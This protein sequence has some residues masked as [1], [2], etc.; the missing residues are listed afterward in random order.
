MT[1]E[2]SA[3]TETARVSA[4]AERRATSSAISGARA[5]SAEAG[6]RAVH[7]DA[8]Q[9]R[10]VGAPVGRH[11]A[12]LG[13]PGTGKTTVV[14][15][16]VA[17]RIATGAR[18]TDEIMVI[19]ADRRAATR[20]RD[21]LAV[22]VGVPT[23]GPLARALTSFA[24]GIVVAGN[25][26]DG[27]PAP[28][29]LT[30]GEQDAVIADLLLGDD[31][32]GRSDDW[33]AHL[34]AEVRSLPGFRGELRELMA[35]AVEAHVSPSLL[36]ELGDRRLRAEWRAAG[37][38]I[39]QYHE[40]VDAFRDQFYDSTELVHRATEIV[41]GAGPSGT[42][43]GPFAR[44]RSLVVD[45]AEELSAAGA[46]LLAAF[47]RRG[48]DIV[49][50][51][52]PDVACGGFRG[53]NPDVVSRLPQVLDAPADT[54]VLGSSY[55]G[56]RQLADV[57]ERVVARVGTAGAG[58]QRRVRRPNRSVEEP[59]LVTTPSSVAEQVAIVARE[60]RERHVFA[61]V[62]WHDMAVVV[63]SRS[64]IAA[65]ERGL[66]GL[67]VP[68]RVL[69]GGTAL[70]DEPSVRAFV[71]A[72]RVALGVRRLDDSSAEELL[73]SVLGGFDRVELRRLRAA[74][75]QREADAGGVRS[76][77][78]LL[79]E[80]MQL[81]GSLTDLDTRHGRKAQ[82]LADNLRRAEASAADGATVEE[83][84]W[85]LW[86]RARLERALVEQSRGT[87]LAADEANRTLDAIVA[88]FAAA[89]RAVERSPGE[90]PAHFLDQLT[91]SD[92]PEDTLAPRAAGSA[93]V[94]T[95]PVGTVDRDFDTVVICG[96]QEHG[97]PN[98]RQRGTLLASGELADAAAGIDPTPSDARALVLHD[99]LRLLARTV[100]RARERL[101][102]SAVSGE[103]SAPSPFL[104][105]FPPPTDGLVERHPL[106]LR[107]LTARLRRDLTVAIERGEY[108]AAERAAVSLARLA[109][110]D[111]DGADPHDWS[112]LLD[113]STDA[114][115]VSAE[116]TVRVS[117]SRVQAFRT[118]G[119]H[120]LIDELGGSTAT[121][122]SG[123]GTIL[124]EVAENLEST[125]ADEIWRAMAARWS[126]LP[127]EAGW[128]ASLEEV[129]GRDLARRLALYLASLESRGATVIGKEVAFELPIPLVVPAEDGRPESPDT[130]THSP[131]AVAHA[132]D[133]GP[134]MAV[135]RGTIDRV[136][137]VRDGTID[138]VDLK[139]GKNEPK[140]DAGVVDN[141]QLGA[142]QLAILEGAVPGVDGH[143][144]AGAK[145]VVLAGAAKTKAFYE[146]RQ[147]PFSHEQAVAFREGIAATAREM[148]GSAFPAHVSSHCLEPFSF[149]RCRIHVIEAVTS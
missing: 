88:L 45:D 118:C 31:E 2:T 29:L 101:V 81:P 92:L 109:R 37:R 144:G 61:G 124:H 65:L 40:V 68:T 35:R 102:V 73:T 87:G 132:P 128:Q 71:L 99:E 105:L 82:S 106:S 83:L 50:T 19:A 127:F 120:W 66:A 32:D 1:S 6:S 94:I 60:L 108:A 36:E 103:D 107:G 114:P 24:F 93:V 47:A 69:A 91:E 115:L 64:Q 112:G 78:E 42:G 15:E 146:P 116:E 111:V 56:S 147:E 14:V 79:V 74:L 141:P 139:T 135:L 7:L 49:V 104:P 67:E 138:I 33:P 97:W 136:E 5:G 18:A 43:L 110:N 123:L 95:T 48:V 70:R 84:L 100:S 28:R 90:S 38:F 119:L 39:R 122:A 85:G 30:G 57:Y 131:D 10:V 34:D 17:E 21:V 149:G 58:A 26:H 133:D 22:R 46:E 98:M 20:L 8:D 113:V 4:S 44:L 86:E 121:V 134:T 117:P 27:L 3:T 9:R 80:A 16:L 13:A 96:L 140:T 145:L 72:S 142:Y 130:A 53:A 75:R 77:G 59:V 51:G 129:K 54:A 25:A 23:A 137:L 62:P 143:A 12:V 89:R 55:R 63:R 76:A 126:E 41:D 125:D 148:A 52:D 11:L